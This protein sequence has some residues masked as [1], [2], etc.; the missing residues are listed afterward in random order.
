MRALT[1]LFI[2]AAVSVATGQ[3]TVCF[4]VE[5]NPDAGQ[6]AFSGFTKYVNVFGFKVY[7]EN[8]ITDAQMKHVASVT[9]ELLDND[10]DGTVDDAALLSQLLSQGALMPVFNSEGSP[11]MD[12]FENNYNGDGVSAILFADEIDPSQPGHWGDDATV[13]EVLHTINH[14]GHIQ[15]YPSIFGIGPNSSTMSDAMDVARGGQF[16]TIP[17]PYPA[18]AWYHYDDVTCDYGCMA[19]EYIYWCIVSNMGILNDAATCAGIA[20]EWEPCSPSLFQTTDVAMYALITD[21]QYKLPQLAPDGNY[22]PTGMGITEQE[23]NPLISI[24]P[25]PAGTYLTVRLSK[26]SALRIIDAKGAVVHSQTCKEGETTIDV[27]ALAAG[28]YRLS[29]NNSTV[30]FSINR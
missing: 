16:L 30:Q 27:S 1:P 18:A 26:E 4:D 14:V 3:N 17:N 19:V 10:E 5:A 2:I 9:A 13:E 21:P 7:G 6:A 12:A 15:M 23:S 29:G 24:F 28:M 11:A 20:D 25:N 22:C 8:N